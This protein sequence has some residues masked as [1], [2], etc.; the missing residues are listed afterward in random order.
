MNT[1]TVVIGLTQS[2]RT[3]DYFP[4]SDG[5]REGAAQQVVSVE[6][7]TGLLVGKSIEAVAEAVF[8]ATNAPV[9]V[10]AR[11]PLACAILEGLLDP[12]G[13]GQYRSLSVG[14]TVEVDGTRVACDRFG[15][16]AL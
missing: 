15:W 6:V 16:K 11:N 9:E 7:E 10:F 3:G 12:M 1:T 5:Y 4:M 14:D 8:E 13:R 2:A